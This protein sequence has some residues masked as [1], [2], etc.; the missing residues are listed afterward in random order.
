MSQATISKKSVEII[1]G[2]WEELQKRAA[3][4]EGRQLRLHILPGPAEMEDHGPRPKQLMSEAIKEILE[5]AAHLD[6][7]PV[8]LGKYP[9]LLEK[10][11]NNRRLP[12]DLH[13]PEV[14]E[15]E[16]A[17]PEGAEPAV[18]EPEGEPGR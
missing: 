17:E 14:A 9:G 4:F 13:E 10:H 12:P 15:P 18:A 16:G 3:D 2:T 8:E 5:E 6:S 11:L 7:T 1:E